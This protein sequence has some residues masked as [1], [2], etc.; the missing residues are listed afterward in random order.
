[1]MTSKYFII[2]HILQVI[3]LDYRTNLIAETRYLIPFDT[4]QIA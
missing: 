4:S 3:N 1:M 2:P